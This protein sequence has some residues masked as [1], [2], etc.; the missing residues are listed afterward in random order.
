MQVKHIAIDQAE[1]TSLSWLRQLLHLDRLPQTVCHAQL[2]KYRTQMMA[3]D[4]FWQVALTMEAPH[5]LRIT[6]HEKWTTIPV[7]RAA[8]GGNSILR[9]LGIY[10]THLWGRALTLGGEFRRYDRTTPGGVLYMNGQVGENLQHHFNLQYW[11]LERRTLAYSPNG[12]AIGQTSYSNRSL[13]LVWDQKISPSSFWRLGII[14]QPFLNRDWQLDVSGSANRAI[15]TSLQRKTIF[16]LR[17]VAGQVYPDNIM[18]TGSKLI[19]EPLLE[20]YPQKRHFTSA[21]KLEGFTF[22]RPSYHWNYALHGVALGSLS[23][24]SDTQVSL[25][26]LDSVRGLPDGFMRGSHATWINLEARFLALQQKQLWIQPVIFI[27]GAVLKQASGCQTCGP[28]SAVTTGLGVR[29]AVPQIK[30]F[31]VRIDSAWSLSRPWTFSI[32]AGMNQF[33]QPMHPLEGR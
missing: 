4:V 5:T 7:I 22:W 30:R 33:F 17:A 31:V 3:T 6:V 25:G 28:S 23:S 2:S 18:L 12:A 9:V 14:I 13:R 1:R 8:V 32:S 10:D 19:L 29:F 27:D 11:Q 26:G 15:S 16:G 21:W 24:S 20:W